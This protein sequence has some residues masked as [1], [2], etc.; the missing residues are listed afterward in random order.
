MDCF[1]F[2]KTAV[3]EANSFYAVLP[4]VANI[5]LS[6]G[7]RL[8]FLRFCFFEAFKAFKSF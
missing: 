2:L 6:T 8:F 4:F 3:S 1:G 5:E 7:A